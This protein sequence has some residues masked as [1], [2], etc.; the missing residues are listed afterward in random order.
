[1]FTN[2]NYMVIFKDRNQGIN[3]YRKSNCYSIFFNEFLKIITCSVFAV[4]TIKNVHN[5][6][7]RL[8]NNIK[9]IISYFLID[10]SKI[11][12]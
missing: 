4:V 11:Y 7:V 12:Y 5:Y 3:N 9:N 6:A 2:V 1:M 8:K 10:L